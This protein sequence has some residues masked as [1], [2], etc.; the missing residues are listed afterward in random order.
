MERTFVDVYFHAVDGR[1]GRFDGEFGRIAECAAEVG[2][3]TAVVEHV[4]GNAHKFGAV[5]QKPFVGCDVGTPF[6]YV[7]AHFRQGFVAEETASENV[8]RRASCEKFVGNLFECGAAVESLLEVR[9]VGKPLE[10]ARRQ[11]FE[12][13]ISGEGVFQ[14]RDLRASGRK[15]RPEWF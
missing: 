7:S 10:Q 6:E 14:R 12:G 4:G 8:G 5:C 1:V 15:I 9:G 13:R 3:L 2:D 11:R